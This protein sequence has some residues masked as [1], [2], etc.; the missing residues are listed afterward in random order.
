MFYILGDLQ[1]GAVLLFTLKQE[2]FL[3]LSSYIQTV[4]E[5]NIQVDSQGK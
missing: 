5:N 2:S 4:R 3:E 1:G